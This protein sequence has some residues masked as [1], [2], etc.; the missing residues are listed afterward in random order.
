MKFT[1][2]CEAF[3]LIAEDVPVR[4]ATADELS[5]LRREL[6]AAGLIV[7]RRQS[8]SSEEMQRIASGLSETGERPAK[9]SSIC[10]FSNLSDERGRPV[11]A[12]DLAAKVWANPTDMSGD[13]RFQMLYAIETPIAGGELHW[14]DAS[15][16]F[17]AL[18]SERQERLKRLRIQQGTGSFLGRLLGNAARMPGVPVAF[19]DADGRIRVTLPAAPDRLEGLIGNEADAVSS[20]D[21]DALTA[22]RFVYVHQWNTGDLVLWDRRRFLCRREPFTGAYLMKALCFD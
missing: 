6:E 17:S 13:Q 8:L 20:S 16:A 14:C 21:L 19:E 1:K 22:D 18:R 5:R 2:V 10:F 11:G 3:G 7:M 12:E 9:Q 4:K 15:S